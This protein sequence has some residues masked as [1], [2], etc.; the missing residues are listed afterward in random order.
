MKEMVLIN[1]TVR[2]LKDLKFMDEINSSIESSFHTRIV[3]RFRTRKATQPEDTVFGFI[4][5]FSNFD[6]EGFTYGMKAEL[7]F[8]NFARAVIQSTSSLDILTHVVSTR[9]EA[10]LLSGKVPYIIRKNKLSVSDGQAW[11]FLGDSYVH[12]IMMEK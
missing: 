6:D 11:T 4:G 9:I 2:F 8:E 1:R 3:A 7:I 10:E 5:L 12:G